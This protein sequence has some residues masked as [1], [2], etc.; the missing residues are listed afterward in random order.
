M[1]EGTVS[2]NVR[3]CGSVPRTCPNELK[4]PDQDWYVAGRDPQP[5]PP[6]LGKHMKL[7]DTAIDV[8]ARTFTDAAHVLKEQLV[9]QGVRVWVSPGCLKEFAGVASSAAVR[10][11]QAG[12]S[13]RSS[14]R[15]EMR[16]RT[17]FIQEWT[18]SDRKFEPPQADELVAIAR[19]YA[20]PRPWRATQPGAS[21]R[22]EAN[23]V[24]IAPRHISIARR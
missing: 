11:R 1:R 23:V 2:V 3:K 22:E 8:F 17:Q 15:R 10:T 16:A 24:V 7:L 21:V 19:K 5:G 18:G 12:E 14:L 4:L 9:E 6:A 20:L 13:Y